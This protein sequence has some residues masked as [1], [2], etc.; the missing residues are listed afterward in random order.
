MLKSSDRR[1][2]LRL[3]ELRSSSSSS[4]NKLRYV[5]FILNSFRM[6][7]EKV[8]SQKEQQQKVEKFKS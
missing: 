3:V 5:D 1:R 2:W 6:N 7:E 4:D 8:A